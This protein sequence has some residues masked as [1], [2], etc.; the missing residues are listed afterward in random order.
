MLS[1]Y[2]ILTLFQIGQ[3]S[4]QQPQN[5]TNIQKSFTQLFQEKYSRNV[6]DAEVNK[7]IERDNLDFNKNV[8]ATVEYE[9]PTT[10]LL[11][12]ELITENDFIFNK[13]LF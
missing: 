8:Q 6:L 2:C 4:A 7:Q 5:T 12:G 13:F 11:R 3:A 1:S 9:S 10:V